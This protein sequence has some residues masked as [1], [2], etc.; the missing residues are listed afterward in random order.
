MLGVTPAKSLDDA[1][2][3]IADLAKIPETCR[4][5]FRNLVRSAVDDLC[6]PNVK[7]LKPFSDDSIASQLRAV[8]RNAHALLTQLKTMENGSLAANNTLGVAGLSVRAAA[9]D[10]GLAI[11][12]FINQLELL[13]EATEAAASDVR[14]RQD[15]ITRAHTGRP[16]GTAGNLGFD[17]F[18]RQLLMDAQKMGGNLT[19]F[20]SPSADGGW[21]GS[22]LKSI[23]LLRHH[24]LDEFVPKASLGQQLYRIAHSHKEDAQ[25]R[26]SLP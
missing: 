14:A 9:K 7:K 8:I 16:R 10:R 24:L 25:P 23:E 13:V 6:T 4:S 21:N 12:H 5:N 22:L 2:D 26:N 20:K 19:I 15:R 11:K 1:L 17:I 18:V 3:E